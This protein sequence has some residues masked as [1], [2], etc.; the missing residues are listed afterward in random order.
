[1][2]QVNQKELANIESGH[3]TSHAISARKGSDMMGQKLQTQLISLCACRSCDPTA[4]AAG[5]GTW[6]ATAS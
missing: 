6:P 2:A 3:G 1:M 4:L 5:P